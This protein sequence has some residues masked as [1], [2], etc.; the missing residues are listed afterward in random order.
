M[1]TLAIANELEKKLSTVAEHQGKTMSDLVNELI[2]DYLENIEA[3]QLAEAALKRIESGESK[4]IEWEEAKREL[5][6][7][8]H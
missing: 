8:D 5:H 3:A 2:S 6:G 4:L 7:L 1:K